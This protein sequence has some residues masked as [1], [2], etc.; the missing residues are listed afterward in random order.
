MWRHLYC[1]CLSAYQSSNFPREALVALCSP[2]YSPDLCADALL[3]ERGEVAVSCEELNE[4]RVLAANGADNA[5][6]AQETADLI[7]LLHQ[8]R[9]SNLTVSAKS[10]LCFLPHPRTF[11][12]LQPDSAYCNVAWNLYTHIGFRVRQLFVC[13]CHLQLLTRC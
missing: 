12:H 9:S 3:A 11:S 13:W 6:L 2:G 10:H 1:C 7:A 5:E 8:A 4:L